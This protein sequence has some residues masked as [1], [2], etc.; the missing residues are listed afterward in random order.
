[1]PKQLPRM[2]DWNGKD[3]P[4]VLRSLPA[5]RYVI[6]DI[7]AARELTAAED[8]GLRQALRSVS[9]ART[10]PASAAHAQLR[11]LIKRTSKSTHQPA[12]RR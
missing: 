8:A 3:L 7:S 2:V 4:K 10:T 1:M 12:A 9:A 5:G 11:S 6:E